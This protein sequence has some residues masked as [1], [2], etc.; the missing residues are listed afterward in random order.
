MRYPLDSHPRAGTGLVQH[1]N[2]APFK[3]A[4]ADA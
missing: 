4:R 1:L 3:D 2:G